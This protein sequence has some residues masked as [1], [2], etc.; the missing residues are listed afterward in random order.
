[1]SKR[2][3]D[4]IFALHNGPLHIPPVLSGALQEVTRAA[5]FDIAEG[6]GFPVEEGLL[7]R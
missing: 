3:D 4:S 2:T 5:L 1:M 7:T 6:P